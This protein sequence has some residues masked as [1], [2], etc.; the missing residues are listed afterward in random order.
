M[1]KRDNRKRENLIKLSKLIVLIG[2]SGFI[3]YLLKRNGDLK[4]E[5]YIVSGEKKNLDITIKGLERTLSQ[6]NYQLGKLST[7]RNI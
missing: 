6:L 3:Y 1:E 5:L 7:K 2:V 4:K